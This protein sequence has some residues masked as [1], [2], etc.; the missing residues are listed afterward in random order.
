MI[1]GE[2]SYIPCSRHMPNERV[3]AEGYDIWPML[4]STA[5]LR[6]NRFIEV[7]VCY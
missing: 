1:D 5:L 3:A 4:A 2:Q 6:L 7:R